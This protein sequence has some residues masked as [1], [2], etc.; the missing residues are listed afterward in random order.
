VTGPAKF[1]G[2]NKE[3]RYPLSRIWDV[4]KPHALF[5]L[6]N[7]STADCSSDDPTVAKCQARCRDQNLDFSQADGH[8]TDAIRLGS[9]P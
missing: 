4:N 2:K 3:Y 7:P 9:S 5:V 1:G 8:L 6:M